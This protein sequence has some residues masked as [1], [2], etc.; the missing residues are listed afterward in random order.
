MP[1]SDY[2]QI[3][4]VLHVVQQVN[5][6]KVLDVGVGFGKWGLLCREILEIYQERVQPETWTAT[7]HG[8]E[9]HEPYRNPLWALAY[10]HIYI[11]DAMEMLDCLGH[12]DLILCCD[13]IEHFE[14]DRGR[15]LLS[16]F[17]QHA[18]VAVLTSPRG[19]APQ[20]AIYGN[21]NERHRSQWREEDFRDSP[22]L[23][24]DIGFTFMAV[25]GSDQ[26]RLKGIELN[27]PMKILG[28]KRAVPE[29]IRLIANRGKQRLRAALSTMK[30]PI[31]P[32]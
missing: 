16:K 23:Y 32:A 22:H 2:H 21:E 3:S 11:G 30:S 7:I 28:A 9:I 6:T 27:D 29:V 12:Y 17:L 13:V 1:V 4:D 31:E 10:D 19:L 8:I 20:G 5:P 18:K 24:K 25:V 15:V 14:K 26:S